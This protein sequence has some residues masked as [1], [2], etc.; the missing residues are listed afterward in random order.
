MTDLEVTDRIYEDKTR[1]L[2][3]SD[4]IVR[5]DQPNSNLLFLDR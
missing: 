5:C 2:V 1:V 4:D 3:V